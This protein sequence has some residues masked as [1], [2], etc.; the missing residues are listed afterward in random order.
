MVIYDMLLLNKTIVCFIYEMKK[1]LISR[2]E[3]SME[4]NTRSKLIEVATPL[5]ATKGFVAVSVRE[6]TVAAQS[7]VAAISYYFNGKEGL[8]QAVLEEQYSPL[9]QALGLARN[10][11]S[12]SPIERLTFYAEQIADIHAQRPFLARFMSRELVNATDYGG[13]IIEKHLS[14]LYQFLKTALKEGIAKGEF[15]A[16]LNV[17]FTAVSLAGIL[18]FYFITKPIIRKFIPLTENAN[19]EYTVHAFRV[20]LHGILNPVP[21]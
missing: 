19:V 18:N 7:N 10:N 11:D 16:D 20:F 2:K 3:V 8:Y 5:F 9:L 15:R 6:L 17:P 14:Q 21:K 4:N 1:C 13:P 12:L